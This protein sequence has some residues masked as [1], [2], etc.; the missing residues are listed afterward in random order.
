MPIIAK[1]N[2]T[3]FDPVPTGVYPA[4]CYQVLDLGTQQRQWNGEIKARH[5]LKLVFELL[6]DEKRDDGKPY[7]ISKTFTLSL[8]ENSALRPFLEAWRGK[9]FTA[10][11]LDGFDIAKLV[12][13]YC[14]INVMHETGKDGKST[15]AVIGSVMPLGKQD[16]PD[17][18][19]PN[20]VFT[21]DPWDQEV[22]DNL[23]E[24]TQETIKAAYEYHEMFGD[25]NKGHIDG[26]GNKKGGEDVVI[27]DIGDEP[28][29]LDDIP[30]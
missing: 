12:G 23:H 21:F 1:D 9:A 14:Q 30:F 18:V 16:K 15:F 17:A 20:L 28:I 4:R 2:S 6:G 5:E 8:A 29:N 26:V 22:F 3:S 19:N 7:S 27:E 24:K 10:E 13:A 11:E 25:K